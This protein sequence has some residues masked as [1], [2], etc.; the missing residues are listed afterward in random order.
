MTE[1]RDAWIH[2]VGED[3]AAGDLAALYHRTRDRRTGKVDN[4]LRIHGQRPRTLEAHWLLYRTVMYGRSG[5]SRAER[6]MVAVVAS[7]AN[8][9]H[10]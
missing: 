1:E 6:E 2:M 10:Y 5:L 9:C 3:E 8:R 4:I 7:A